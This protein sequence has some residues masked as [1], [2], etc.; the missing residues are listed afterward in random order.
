MYAPWWYRMRY[1][2]KCVMPD[3]KP[4]VVLDEARVCQA[5]RHAGERK[6]V[7][8]DARFKELKKLCDKYRRND[9]YY[10]CIIAVSGGKDSIFQ[11]YVIKELMGMNPLLV[12]AK[13]LFSMTKAGEHNF[14]NMGDTFGC[15]IIP[16][17]FNRRI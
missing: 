15:D 16:L 17:H 2:K 12:C 11:I 3:T 7:D 14:K 1:C 8:W 6:K 9:S 13:S 5:C 4:S 10:D